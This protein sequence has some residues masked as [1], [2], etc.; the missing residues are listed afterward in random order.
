[1]FDDKYATWRVITHKDMYNMVYMSL[2][3]HGNWITDHEKMGAW[4]ANLYEIYISIP[5]TKL[6]QFAWYITSF[7]YPYN[8]SENVGKYT[9]GLIKTLQIPYIC[10]LYVN[11]YT[12]LNCSNL[13]LNL[14]WHMVLCTSIFL[15]LSI[16]CFKT[17]TQA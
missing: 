2:I 10:Y 15:S 14:Y 1:M 7:L 8:E 3:P 5:V 12:K 13:K 16:C 4:L 17:K 11:L 6:G 9:I